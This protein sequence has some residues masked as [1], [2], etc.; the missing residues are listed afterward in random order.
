MRKKTRG[1]SWQGRAGSEGS[2]WVDAGRPPLSRQER[3]PG[4]AGP[5]KS[6][7]GGRK[8][9]G[10]GGGGD[11]VPEP[12]ARDFFGPFRPTNESGKTPATVFIVPRPG[13]RIPRCGKCDAAG[14]G[15]GDRGIGGSGPLPILWQ[16]RSQ[17]GRGLSSGLSVPC[18]P[19]TYSA[20]GGLL[21]RPPSTAPPSVPAQGSSFGL[22]P[23][24]RPR[25]S[26][27]LPEEKR[28]SW[29]SGDGSGRGQKRPEE[30][31]TPVFSLSS[32]ILSPLPHGPSPEVL[33]PPWGFSSDFVEESGTI[34]IG[35]TGCRTGPFRSLCANGPFSARRLLPGASGK[36]LASGVA[37]RFSPEGVLPIFWT[38]FCGRPPC[39][40]ESRRAS[41]TRR[42]KRETDNRQDPFPPSRQGE[43]TGPQRVTTGVL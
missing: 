15:T 14:R 20:P 6:R 34:G 3:D 18:R 42:G 33:F 28:G 8:A 24:D 39:P 26:H 38:G 23:G 31:G 41:G 13:E 32:P 17:G 10:D 36:I 1:G 11:P 29:S 21:S 12:W 43:G 5:G 9:R 25:S 30:E 7:N 40:G 2:S 22:P 37:E 27:S 16:D 35:A 4:G 19:R